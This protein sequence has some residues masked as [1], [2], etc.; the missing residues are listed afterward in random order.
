MTKRL[1]YENIFW[2][3]VMHLGAIAAIPMFSWTALAICLVLLFSISSIGI[4]MT[5]HRLLT[6]RGFKVPQWF[7]YVLSTI[8]AMSGQ[9]PMLLWVA[10]HR[11][12]HRYSDTEKD[13]HSPKQGFFHAHMGHLFCHKEFEDEPDQWMTY[14]P[15][16][17][18]H[19]YY[20]F[21]SNYAALFVAIPAVILYPLGG[22][23]FVLWGVCARIV[24]MWHVTWSVNS[25][26]HTWGYRTFETADTSRNLWWVGWFGGGEGWHNNHHAYPVS[27]AHGRKWYEFD[28]TC[29]MILALKAAGLATNVKMPVLDSKPDYEL[30]PFSLKRRPA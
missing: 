18:Q 15:D 19:G 7:E 8:A 29:Y 16:L 30:N 6:H 9:G 25:A 26:C 21:L 1:H 11:L 5:Y 28:Q 10:E 13:P 24:L 12:H 20:R 14:V 2:I 27:A 22:I 3:T 23:P 4:N 17:F